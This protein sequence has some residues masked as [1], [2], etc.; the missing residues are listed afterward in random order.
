M[1]SRAALKMIRKYKFLILFCKFYTVFFKGY[2][3]HDFWYPKK[4]VELT[5]HQDIEAQLYLLT[6]WMLVFL[7]VN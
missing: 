4:V 5:T 1:S 6:E 3:T 7:S 2:N